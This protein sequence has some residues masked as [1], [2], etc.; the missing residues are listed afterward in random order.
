LRLL[1][2]MG[3]AWN[4]GWV[5]VCVAG[6]LPLLF[7]ATLARP[8]LFSLLLVLLA[9]Y[10]T[11]KHKAAGLAITSAIH[12][13]SYSMFFL[14]GL[15]PGIYCL[16]RRDRRSITLLASSMGGVLLG[17]LANPFF[18]ENVR[19][20]IT[21]AFGPI[22][23]GAR[24]NLEIGPELKPLTIWAIVAS[25]PVVA[26]WAVAVVE[27]LRR[28]RDSKLSPGVLVMLLA[29]LGAFL[30]SLGAARTFDYF[31]PFAVLFAAAVLSPWIEKNRKDARYLA[32]ML[33]GFCILN[34]AMAFGGVSNAPSISSYSGASEYLRRHG[35]DAVVFNTQWSQYPFLY[36]WNA[37]SRYVNGIDPTF[38]FMNDA[39]RYWMW[40]HISD[41]ETETCGQPQCKP[42][43]A[44]G[45]HAA[46]ARWFSA[47][48]IL[49]EPSE[50]PR[51]AADLVVDPGFRQV[52]TDPRV[53]LFAVLPHSS[54]GD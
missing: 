52:Y 50:N 27:T 25:L 23:L 54:P 33:L 18:P 7:R 39:E 20:D 2:L 26:S 3:C 22:A 9:A 36:F 12:A 48:Y 40:R 30:V 21:T 53:K 41:D 14:V 42:G 15:A 6:S 16:I 4:T 19:F 49:I 8:F 10:F 45:V 47:S 46:V 34:V 29:S 13:L 28:R 51:L 35:R 37:G 31:V 5:L 17:L 1:R 44:M 11:L 32:A 38:L 24:H 43:T